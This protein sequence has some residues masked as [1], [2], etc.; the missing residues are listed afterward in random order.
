MESL[1][2]AVGTSDMA[3]FILG[4]HW[5]YALVG[6]AH[7]LGI[8]MALGTIVALDARIFGI[9]RSVPLSTVARFLMPFTIAG[10]V[11]AV[12]AGLVLFS[13]RAHDYAGNPVFQLKMA[14]LVLALVNATLVRRLSLHRAEANGVLRIGAA[15]SLVLWIG[16]LVCGRFVASAG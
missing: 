14:L 16:V 5:L 6:A 4:S 13:A 11:L 7:I 3:G 8:A 15:A 1:L 12:L 2:P 9:R 10:L